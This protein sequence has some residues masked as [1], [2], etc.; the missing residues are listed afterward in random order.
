MVVMGRRPSFGVV[1]LATHG[2]S[3]EG[4]I[5]TSRIA[6][7][8]LEP[9]AAAAVANLLS[10]Y[11]NGD[12]SSLCVWADQIQK[13]YR[14]RWTS[15]L[16]FIDTPAGACS[17]LSLS[18]GRKGRVLPVQSKTLPHNFCSSGRDLWIVSP[19]HVGFTSDEG[20]NT[21]ALRWFRHKSNLDHVWDREIILTAL[22]DYYENNLD[23]LQEDLV[24]NFTD[25]IWHD[26]V[27][28][29]E[30][31]DD[32]LQCSNKYATESITIACK[33]GYNGIKYGQTL[34]EEYFY[35]KMPI[36]MKRI[37]QGG[38]RLAMILNK[39]LGGSEEGF[40]AAT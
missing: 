8:L 37:A 14:Y 31:C 10:D 15:P 18:A 5:L 4:H 40:T 36:L 17:G 32:L 9:E 7:G 21:I 1:L 11:A 24:G 2:W 35:S 3:K 38:V 29:W 13:W 6:Q 39:V 12:L 28:S 22:K 34:A 20:G 23:T 33:W 26:D 27:A 16:H 19:M 30:Q 25:G